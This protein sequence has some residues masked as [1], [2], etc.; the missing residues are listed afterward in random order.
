MHGHHLKNQEVSALMAEMCTG[1]GIEDV[2]DGIVTE[3]MPVLKDVPP[4]TKWLVVH[5]M[6]YVNNSLEPPE[7]K[8][9]ISNFGVLVT[10]LGERGAALDNTRY[11]RCLI[12]LNGVHLWINKKQRIGNDNSF[13]KVFSTMKQI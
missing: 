11:S 4:K 7:A 5:K 9:N 6:Y 12:Q 2:P 1:H 13:S 10:C 8:R 3:S